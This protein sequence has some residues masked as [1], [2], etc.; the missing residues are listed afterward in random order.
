MISKLYTA[1]NT[2]YTKV[3]NA[4]A[5]VNTPYLNQAAANNPINVAFVDAIAQLV[6]DCAQ[7]ST[8]LGGPGIGS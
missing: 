5:S 6:I 4:V 7:L 3:V 1:Q 2:A 8:D